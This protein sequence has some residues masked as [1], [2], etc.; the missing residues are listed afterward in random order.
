MVQR[1][2]EARGQSPAGA[3][4]GQDQGGAF[5]PP[6]R[7]EGGSTSGPGRM[8]GKWHQLSPVGGCPRNGTKCPLCHPGLCGLLVQ[9]TPQRAWSA[10]GGISHRHGAG[11]A[12]WRSTCTRDSLTRGVLVCYKFIRTHM[13]SEC[14]C[15][16]SH[17]FDAVL[18]H[19][20][21]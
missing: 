7:G 19:G 17:V 9:G 20:V 14:F 4:R 8:R 3:G 12:I 16:F 21:Q 13:C 15:S 1:R 10:G 6:A 11:R 2:E 5:E 18:M